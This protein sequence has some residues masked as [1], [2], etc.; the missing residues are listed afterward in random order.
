MVLTDGQW[1]LLEPLIL[2]VRPR[3]KTRHHDLRRTIEAI[4]WRHQ[5]GAKWRSLPAEL[6]PWRLAAPTFIRWSRLGAWERLLARAQERGVEL[7]MT[8]LDG[9]TIRTHPKAAGA[10]KR[11]STTQGA[12]CVRRLAALVAAMAPKPA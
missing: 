6:G 12:T 8:F 3:G 9:T 2:E 5:N 1:A 4:F 10:E 11:G 7:G